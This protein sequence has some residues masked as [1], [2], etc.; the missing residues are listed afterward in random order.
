M[1][2]SG[3]QS[4]SRR[5]KSAGTYNLRDRSHMT[6]S[7]RGGRGFQMMTIDDEGGG[8]FWPMMTSSQKSKFC[9]NFKILQGIF[10]NFPPIF[11]N[12]PPIFKNFSPKFSQKFTDSEQNFSSK[13]KQN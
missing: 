5:G 10:Q 2:A 8:G 4:T 3:Y 1:L 7:L 13:F 6:S 12:F 11:Q 9:V